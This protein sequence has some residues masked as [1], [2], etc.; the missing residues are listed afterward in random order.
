MGTTANNATLDT[1]SSTTTNDT[2]AVNQTAPMD[3]TNQTS[4]GS[5]PNAKIVDSN[6]SSDGGSTDTTNV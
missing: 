6:S 3:S 2:M 5:D 1:N 4:I